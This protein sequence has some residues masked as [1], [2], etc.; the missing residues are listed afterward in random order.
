MTGMHGRMGTSVWAPLLRE[1]IHTGDGYGFF[2]NSVI[3]H[4][5]RVK[6]TLE[7]AGKFL[8]GVGLKYFVIFAC[9]SRKKGEYGVWVR[10]PSGPLMLKESA[11]S[12]SFGYKLPGYF[13]EYG[14]IEACSE[15]AAKGV[16]RQRLGVSRLPSGLLVWDLAERPLARWRVAQVS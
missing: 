14:P 6:K 2:D 8:D 7:R 15:A 11:M 3:D 10:K 5:L 16:I 1:P 13:M 9:L 4:E 12:R